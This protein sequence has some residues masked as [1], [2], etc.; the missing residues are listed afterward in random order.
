MGSFE[1]Q[2]ERKHFTTKPS[3]Q[4][5]TH[6]TGSFIR[7]EVVLCDEHKKRECPLVLLNRLA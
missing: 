5:S 4:Q 7:E 6:L 2:Q 1:T 3:A